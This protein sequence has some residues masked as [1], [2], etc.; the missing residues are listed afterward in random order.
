[1]PQMEF[2]AFL[3][4][5]PGFS[6]PDWVWLIADPQIAAAQDYAKK[7]AA[8]GGLCFEDYLK[9]FKQIRVCAKQRSLLAQKFAESFFVHLAHV[10]ENTNTLQFDRYDF[11]ADRIV[12]TIPLSTIVRLAMRSGR[13]DLAPLL[14]AVQQ[15]GDAWAEPTTDGPDPAVT[16]CRRR[17]DPTFLSS[18]LGASVEASIEPLILQKLKGAAANFAFGQSVDWD[19][20]DSALADRRHEKKQNAV[21][22]AVAVANG[23]ASR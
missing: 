19:K 22:N 2:K 10:M 7:E 9:I 15:L 17:L 23:P 16:E 5:F 11:D 3:P 4:H 21:A 18:M 6:S 1:M 13:V 12:V 8:E 20:F 14:K